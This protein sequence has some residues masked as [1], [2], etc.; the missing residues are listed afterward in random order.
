MKETK[1]TRGKIYADYS[2]RGIIT[3]KPPSQ[4]DEATRAFAEL[5]VR[6]AMR[7]GFPEW[8]TNH[9]ELMRIARGMMGEEQRTFGEDDRSNDIFGGR[10]SD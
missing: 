5:Q 3:S 4:W 8:M 10:S 9:P 1:N 7:T 6:Q 2:P